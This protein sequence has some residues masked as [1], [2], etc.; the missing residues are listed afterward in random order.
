M[1]TVRFRPQTVRRFCSL[2]GSPA[3]Q[4][5]AVA[6]SLLAIAGLVVA[7]AAQTGDDEPGV[8]NSM[9]VADTSLWADTDNGFFVF[10]DNRS[11]TTN[12]PVPDAWNI[13]GQPLE[14]D[15]VKIYADGGVQIDIDTEGDSNATVSS[16]LDPT[17]AYVIR[18]SSGDHS[19]TVVHEG[20]IADV[21][22]VPDNADEVRQFHDEL[23]AGTEGTAVVSDEP[24]EPPDVVV[25]SMTVEDT[26]LW[27]DADSGSFVFHDNRSDT[28]NDPVPDAWNIYGQ[29]LEFDAVQVYADGGVQV[30]IDTEDDS[31]S[32][33]SSALDPTVAYVVQLSSGDHSVTVVHEGDIADVK[34]VPDNADEVGEFHDR[35]IAGAD[36]TAVVSDDPALAPADGPDLVVESVS[37]S[38]A[39]LEPGATFTLSATVRN[40]GVADAAA[41]ILRYFRSADATIST[42]DTEVGT[43]AV[44]GLSPSGMSQESISL[45]APRAAGTYHYGACVDPV[46]H[47]SDA[48]DNCSVPVRVDVDGPPPDSAPAAPSVSLNGAETELEVKFKASF[49]ARET[50]A[51]A[52]R[53]RQKTQQS[54]SRTYCRALEYTGDGTVLV[55]ITA[56]VFVGSFVRP[57][58]TYLVD[59]RHVGASCSD[60]TD[61][62]WSQAAEFTTSSLAVGGNFNIDI[63][64]VGQP[65]SPVVSAVN[66][67]ASVWEKAITNDLIDI[68]L[69]GRP[70][71]NPCTD[72]EFDGFVD[73]LRVYVYVQS[74]DGAGGT[75]ASAGICTIR[76]V[77]GFPVIAQIRL[78]SADV[79]EIGSATLYNVAL[80]EIAHTLGFGLLW[81][82]LL[83]DPSLSAGQPITP[84]PDTHFAGSKAIAAFNDAGGTNYDGMKVPVENEEGGLG[85][86]DSHWRKSVMGNELMTFSTG[87][88]AS[89]SAITIESMADLGYSVEDSVA[90]SYTVANIAG[91]TP[92]AEE[93]EPLAGYC[94]VHRP[95][96]IETVPEPGTTALPSPS[97]RM[98]M[99]PIE[100]ELKPR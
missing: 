62:P 74:I 4:A 51:F 63:V 41:T 95:T 19:V 11:D 48:T 97:I 5:G 49:A 68:D 39:T 27:A 96:D 50:K 47:E 60:E 9:T 78:D 14:F 8:V 83:V 92:A 88:S 3:W 7:A 66:S 59:Y 15:A 75:L 42:S 26:S 70:Q 55:T 37:A 87:T 85:S 16:A 34:I 32:T 40:A 22:I 82:G 64:F 100:P 79:D 18:L 35:L 43:D 13:Y 65:S 36:G 56:H 89:F 57:S 71:N 58:T 38:D 29:P 90:D 93:G 1:H 44:G 54:D 67:A 24:P 84:P 21:K 23:A 25:N 33:V 28:T 86:Q 99:D 94:V 91:R 98:Q 17:V 69:S 52:L 30:D 10:H 77:S 73:D 20:D 81:G 72:G 61:N 12:D 46:A 53:I 31:R 80:H 45:Q 6:V 76:S 2:G